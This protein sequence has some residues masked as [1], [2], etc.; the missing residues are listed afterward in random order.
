MLLYD[1]RN[2]TLKLRRPY[3]PNQLDRMGVLLS[4]NPAI[5]SL[6]F[7]AVCFPWVR[8]IIALTLYF[9]SAGIILSSV[10]LSLR[11]AAR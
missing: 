1:L 6:P 10:C 5:S 11:I 2:L 4:Y 3:F 8:T 7:D 9:L